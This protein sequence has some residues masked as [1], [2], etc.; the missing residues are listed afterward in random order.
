MSQFLI[1]VF[2]ILVNQTGSLAYHLVLVFAVV[3]ALQASIL[4]WQRTGFPQGRRMVIGLALILCIQLA[5]FLVAA[6]AWQGLLAPRAF[7][8][9][10]DRA[11]ALLGLLIILWLWAFPEPKRLADAA[12]VLV[13]V[14][15][16]VILGFATVWWGG[17]AAVLAY[18]GSLAE[19]VTDSMA[20]VLSVLGILAL[21]IRRPNSWGLGLTMLVLLFAG[22][23]IELVFLPAVGDY[24]GV[25]RLAQM[26]AYPWLFAL[27]QRFPL[28][29]PVP[30]ISA[31]S[32]QPS[33]LVPERRRYS[34]QPG[35]VTDLLTLATTTSPNHICQDITRLV[36]QIILADFC[37]LVSAPS[38]DGTITIPC[39]YNLIQEKHLEG[40]SLETRNIPVIFSAF[41]RGLALRL[42]SSSTSDDIHFLTKTL[43]LKRLGP[44]MFVPIIGSSG[45]PIM[46]LILIS[47]YSNRGWSV[48]DQNYLVHLAKHLT[49]IL[50]RVRESKELQGELVQ[51][52]QDL[53]AAHGV[54]DQFA[55][56]RQALTSEINRLRHQLNQEKERAESLA[57]LI[58]NQEVT[59]PQLPSLDW[60]P[61]SDTEQLR[62]NDHGDNWL[63]I[64]AELTNEADETRKLEAELRVALEEIARLRNQL[65]H[66]TEMEREGKNVDLDQEMGVS[67]DSHGEV[68]ASIAQELRQPMSSIIGYTDLLLGESVGIL[69]ALQRKFL[70]RVKASVERMGGLADDLIQLTALQEGRLRLSPE[71]VDLNVVIDDAVASS[72]TRLREKS[73][74]LRMDIPTSLPQIHADRDALQQVLIHLL[75]NAGESTPV[76]GEISLHAHI[77]KQENEP[78]YVLLQV[79]DTGGGIPA[80]DLPRVFSRLY[81]ADNPLIEGVGD[82]GVGL[83]IVKTL[84]EAHGGRI[85]VDTAVG[86]GSTFSVLLPMKNGE[87]G[88]RGSM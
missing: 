19:M 62:S 40:F 44:L 79:S 27:P 83:S 85:W 59:T 63:T 77:E 55:E 68:I 2:E 25:V 37:M 48:E 60:I 15:I 23:L 66:L 22:H 33:A 42:P 51:V 84:V 80:E 14:L 56:E 65:D 69:G 52:R 47:P 72:I 45:A 5:Q 24:A 18:N 20:V 10:L 39:I 67:Q 8:P 35:L 11:I 1:Q 82:T 87:T 26:A 54:A 43:H 38:S 7:L 57:G 17:Q 61:E 64:P 50:H 76:E 46:G 78:G 21:L 31:P 53:S 16:I 70:E 74:V 32:G 36:S 13:G 49:T 88:A 9:P 86:H 3:G 75:Q 4:H 12:T 71:T 28:S 29:L 34:I 30:Q 81:H 58:A 73:I 6:L 41:R